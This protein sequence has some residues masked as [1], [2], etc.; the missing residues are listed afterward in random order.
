[1]SPASSDI[2]RIRAIYD[3]LAPAWNQREGFVERV[4][5]G[6][7]MR[8]EL[9][10]HLRGDVLELGS[11]TGVTFPFLDWNG[12]TSLTATDL[13]GGM[14]EEAR[15]HEAIANRPV[16]FREV[17]AS[18]LP[19]GDA[20]FDTVSASLMLCTV[21]DPEG[22]LREMS[23]V[24]QPD[25]RIVILEH[26]RAPNRLL[27]GTQR[28]LS[29]AQQRRMGCHLDRATDNLVREMGFT[30]VDHRTRFFGVF[31]LLVLEPLGVD[32]TGS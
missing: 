9:A 7:A 3:Q 32:H 5:M 19:F 15:R 4:L 24:A 26:V 6:D 20:T 23:R 31:H 21:P 25:G 14:L 22:T 2:D 10:R 13:S 30:I 28:L 12:V 17:D 29:T 27:A 11:G 16:T 18:E 8:R 1:M